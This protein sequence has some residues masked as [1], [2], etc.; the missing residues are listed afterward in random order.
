MPTLG[1]AMI[2]P[3]VVALAN[4]LPGLALC[5]DVRV[6]ALCDADPAT[7]AKASAQTGITNIYTDHK[8]LL[9]RDDLHAVVI[10]TPNFT[11]KPITLDAIAA[12]KHLMCEKP[13]A[14]N[15]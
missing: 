11:H 14:L 7:L 4:H 15:A 10:A 6:V 8:Q 12:G 3:G 5:P 1:I 2:G 13:L 9:Q